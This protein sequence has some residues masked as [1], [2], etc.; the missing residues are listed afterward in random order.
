MKPTLSVNVNLCNP[1]QVFACCGLLELAHRLTA[2][3][4]PAMG[5]FDKTDVPQ[6]QF[7]VEGYTPDGSSV[8][9]DTIWEA[10]KQCS[11]TGDEARKEGPVLLGAPFDFLIDWRK[12]YPQNRLVKTWAG[13]QSIA[14]IA[15]SLRSALKSDPDACIFDVL[16]PT[17]RSVTAFSISKCENARDAGFS[18]DKLGNAFQTHAAAATEFL[19]LIALQRFCPARDDIRLGRSF[20]V[21]DKPLPVTV[22]ALT[23][24]QQTYGVSQRPLAFS[25]YERDSEGRYKAFGIAR[26]T[27]ED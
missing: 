13:Q 18:L 19:A 23:I 27:K 24:C 14:K 11:V 7:L 20:Y 25:M 26:I 12:A 6:T 5:W 3:G 9:L 10:L 8:T 21:W 22:A 17:S 4:R 1:G 16:T 15:L 2:S